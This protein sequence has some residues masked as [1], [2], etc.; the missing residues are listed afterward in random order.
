MPAAEAC[1][2]PAGPE[3]AIAKAAP[4]VSEAASSVQTELGTDHG[5]DLL[6][7]EAGLFSLFKRNMQLLSHPKPQRHLGKK[8]I[9]NLVLLLSP[10]G[11]L[12]TRREQLGK[13]DY[14]LD[15]KQPKKRKDNKKADQS[16]GQGR[17]RALGRGHG[18]GR[19][20]AKQDKDKVSEKGDI[21]EKKEA[22]NSDNDQ[23]TPDQKGDSKNQGTA[24]HE[25]DAKNSDN[26]RDAADHGDEG[27][28]DTKPDRSR[29][30]LKRPASRKAPSAKAKPKT[31]KAEK[32]K[33]QKPKAKSKS[34]TSKTKPA[35]KAADTESDPTSD[36][37]IS[38]ATWAGRWVPSDPIQYAKMCAIKQTF[39]SMVASK[40]RSQSTLQS[41]FYKACIAA[42]KSQRLNDC[43]YEQFLAAAEHEVPSFLQQ[44]D[45]RH[46]AFLFS[47]IRAK[48]GG[49]RTGFLIL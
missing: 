4:V 22:K 45:V 3:A 9:G 38:T 36:K 18:R 47:N 17:G 41:P 6:D 44:E 32:P 27:A 30:P 23:G 14:Q 39:E 49:E 11:A 10:E 12:L 21:S 29:P 20:R 16:S 42:F 37:K 1:P 5:K 33:A 19:G 24:D 7:V 28:E 25:G 13:E 43:G 35:D 34:K 46:L 40:V 2:G 31:A 26:D 15:E 8:H 48:T